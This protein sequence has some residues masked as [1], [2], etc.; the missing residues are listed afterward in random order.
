VPSP[1]ENS[2]RTASNPHSGSVVTAS[3]IPNKV[4]S[5]V[6]GD[7]DALVGPGAR[8]GR[9]AIAAPQVRDRGERNQGKS[10]LAGAEMVDHLVIERA[11]APSAR[12][13][14][15]ARSHRQAWRKA[16]RCPASAAAAAGKARRNCF[17]CQTKANAR[18]TAAPIIERMVGDSQ[19]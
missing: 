5:D 15:R 4:A 3:T 2:E 9:P 10:R 13:A 14:H 6:S 7:G 18:A 19:R 11:D 17:A 16:P 1:S 12:S 8:H